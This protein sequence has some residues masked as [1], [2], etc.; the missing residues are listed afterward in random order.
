MGINWIKRHL[1]L[2]PLLERE[3]LIKKSQKCVCGLTSIKIEMFGQ[4]VVG[5][6][7]KQGIR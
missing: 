3:I 1:L 7:M 4:Q 2:Q 6:G 5:M